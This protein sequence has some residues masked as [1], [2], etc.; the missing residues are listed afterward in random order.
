MSSCTSSA[1]RPTQARMRW[2][3]VA[4]TA[5]CSLRMSPSATTSPSAVPALVTLME[6]TRD[7]LPGLKTSCIPSRF[8]RVRVSRNARRPPLFG[9]SSASKNSLRT[10]VPSAVLRRGFGAGVLPVGR[11]I[12]A[13]PSAGTSTT[14]FAALPSNCAAFTGS[15]AG[16]APPKLSIS[17]AT[18]RVNA[19]GLNTNIPGVFGAALD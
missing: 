6:R 11:G 7:L 17:S 13:N 3:K 18:R 15:T 10:S 14:S 5:S 9:S 12:Q 1:G 4:S 19:H 2:R 8:R 16:I